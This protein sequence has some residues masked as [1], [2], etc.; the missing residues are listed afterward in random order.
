MSINCHK[1]VNY[2]KKD[3]RYNFHIEDSTKYNK[4]IYPLH[5]MKDVNNDISI[6]NSIEDTIK[7]TPRNFKPKN[8]QPNSF[9]DQTRVKKDLFEHFV[10]YDFYGITNIHFKT[11]VYVILFI[12]IIYLC[13]FP[14]NNILN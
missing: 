7:W 8:L 9:Y 3:P 13:I 4:N 14:S 6:Y 10:S 11:F 1:I 5:L 2:N 12:I